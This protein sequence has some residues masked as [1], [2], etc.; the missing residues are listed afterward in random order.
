MRVGEEEEEE[1]ERTACV[2]TPTKQPSLAHSAH[3]QCSKSCYC[4]QCQCTPLRGGN[5]ILNRSPQVGLPVSA[6]GII[7]TNGLRAQQEMK[8]GRRC[9]DLHMFAIAN[10]PWRG[11]DPTRAHPSVTPWNA[12]ADLALLLRLLPL[13]P[14]PR[15]LP[16]SSTFFCFF[17]ATQQRAGGGGACV[18]KTGTFWFSLHGMAMI[19]ALR[20]TT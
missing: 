18:A 13:P 14:T 15:A 1:E 17:S 19:F 6:P 9:A 5:T 8:E 16:H 12:T 2:R 4:I 10:T 11:L 3:E 7:G 20:G